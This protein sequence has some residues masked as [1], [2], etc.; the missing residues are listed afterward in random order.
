MSDGDAIPPADL[1]AIRDAVLEL[2]YVTG[3]VALDVARLPDGLLVGARIG[4]DEGLGFA[5]VA[6]AAVEVR[7]LVE[8][9]APDAVRVY[10]EAEPSRPQGEAY[11]KTDVIVLRAY[12]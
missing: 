9:A 10:V 8:H 6:R 2:P 4:L 11:P 3:L 7:S 1:D 5:D 12:D